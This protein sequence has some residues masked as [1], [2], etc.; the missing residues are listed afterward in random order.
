[1]FK[2]LFGPRHATIRAGLQ[3]YVEMEFAPADRE[4]ALERLFDE[5]TR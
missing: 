4:A 1:M 3:R 5:A 2:F